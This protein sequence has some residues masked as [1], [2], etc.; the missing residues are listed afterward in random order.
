[1]GQ[2]AA[3]TS[4]HSQWRQNRSLTQDFSSLPAGSRS[5]YSPLHDAKKCT[6][7]LQLKSYSST[8]WHWV[9]LNLFHPE[10][11]ILHVGYV[12]EKS[13][14]T[15]TQY[16][17]S[18]VFCKTT[19]RRKEL[20]KE[21]WM[22]PALSIEHQYFISLTWT[23]KDF[24]TVFKSFGQLEDRHRSLMIQPTFDQISY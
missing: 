4:Y 19:A 1:M 6:R 7:E 5:W 18:S 22:L 17:N 9:C 3:P 8:W 20:G 14:L 16:I 24:I 12:W 2:Q 21:H 11:I 23:F 15:L 13:V 10:N